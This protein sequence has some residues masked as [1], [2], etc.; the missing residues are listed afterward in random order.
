MCAMLD[1]PSKRLFLCVE[2]SPGLIWCVPHFSVCSVAFFPGSDITIT[3]AFLLS[4]RSRRVLHLV[5]LVSPWLALAVQII[6]WSVGG[7]GSPRT[8]WVSC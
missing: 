6:R 3:S 4:A 1:A 7:R 8:V 5:C 2:A